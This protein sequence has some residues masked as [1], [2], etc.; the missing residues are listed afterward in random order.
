MKIHTKVYYMFLSIFLF[1]LL[2]ITL[3]DNFYLKYDQKEIQPI[4][5]MH[6]L[7]FS[8]TT[9]SLLGIGDVLPKTHLAR[10]LVMMQVF[11]SIFIVVA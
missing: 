4:E 11:V 6:M 3:H 1:S 10:M 2:Y 7:Y 9:Q 5:Y 8:T